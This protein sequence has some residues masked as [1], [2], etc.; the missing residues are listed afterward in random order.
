[1]PRIHE[2]GRSEREQALDAASHAAQE[3]N[4]CAV[5]AIVAFP[6]IDQEQT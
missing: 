3:N 6:T 5:R 2:V 4:D 1:M